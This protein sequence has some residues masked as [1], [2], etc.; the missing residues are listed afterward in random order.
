MSTVTTQYSGTGDPRRSIELLWGTA[1]RPRR[2]PRPKLTV[3]RI[4]AVALEIADAEGLPALS[5][6]RVAERLDTSTMSLYTYVPGKA[7][8]VDVMFDRVLAEQARP[9]GDPAGDW[10]A[11]LERIA[12][13][14]WALYMRHP[15]L[16]QIATT[17]PPL[18]PNVSAKYEYELAAVAG[19]GLSDLEMDM[20]VSLVARFTQGVAR[21]AVEAAQAERHTGM[22]DLQWWQAHAP[23]LAE[24]MDGSAYP[25]A[26]RVG[27]AVGE[28]YGAASIPPDETF[29]FG[30]ARL[31]DGLAGYLERRQ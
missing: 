5:M 2:G 30:L 13:E 20:V 28:R 10:R 3:D 12:H 27:Q 23:L 7:E 17:R 4:V 19:I 25:H 9:A 22:T 29:R 1:E 6:R 24:V 18:G 21:V 31:L 14:D 15:W 11:R 26:G 8:L 16:L